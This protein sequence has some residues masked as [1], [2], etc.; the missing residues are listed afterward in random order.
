MLSESFLNAP[1][2]KNY[3]L[4]PF[5]FQDPPQARQTSEKCTQV[6]SDEWSQSRNNSGHDPFIIV[7]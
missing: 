7:N 2:I 5:Q 1:D 6:L 3:I 4:K